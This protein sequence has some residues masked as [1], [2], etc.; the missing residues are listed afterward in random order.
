MNYPFSNFNGYTV[1]I[2]EW[3]TNFIPPNIHV[4]ALLFP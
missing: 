2:W 1:E 3:I 4:Y